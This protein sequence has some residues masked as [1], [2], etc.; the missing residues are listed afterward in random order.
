[1]TWDID[2]SGEDGSQS[3]L[4]AS[5]AEAKRRTDAAGGPE[6]YA[7]DSTLQ[8]TELAR[9]EG[10]AKL[11]WVQDRELAR[12]LYQLFWWSQ[13]ED[14]AGRRR[15]EERRQEEHARW[16]SGVL[17]RCRRGDYGRQIR[18]RADVVDESSPSARDT[19]VR[20]LQHERAAAGWPPA[21]G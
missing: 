10:L 9:A 19:F 21:M 12:T 18:E 3:R 5:V 2:S 6:L 1:M 4:P 17:M 14:S 20:W 16:T 7:Y 15:D 11:R 8:P 13:T